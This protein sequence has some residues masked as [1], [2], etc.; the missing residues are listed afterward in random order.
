[1]FLKHLTTVRRLCRCVFKAVFRYTAPFF[2]LCWKGLKLIGLPLWRLLWVESLIADLCGLDI[3]QHVHLASAF[4]IQHSTPP[5]STSKLTRR[6][7]LSNGLARG[8]V[9]GQIVH[10]EQTFNTT[11]SFKSHIFNIRISLLVC[12]YSQCI[13]TN[14][15]GRATFV[16]ILRLFI[17]YH[18]TT[19]V[20]WSRARQ[21][22]MA[23]YGRTS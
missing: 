16:D 13:Y 7:H 19:C 12:T 10:Q 23:S 18:V 17:S 20:L 4:S 11:S 21:I 22:S 5:P 8:D 3:D 14:P 9:I 6:R 15:F 1:M 2:I